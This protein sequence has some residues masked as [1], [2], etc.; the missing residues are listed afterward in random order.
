MVNSRTFKIAYTEEIVRDAVRAFVWKRGISSQKGLWA[1]EA[2]MACLLLWSLSSGH[3]GWLTVV[4]AVGVL[5][6]LCLI[7][8]MW[9]A[10]HRNTVGKY[11]RMP[12]HEAEVTFRDEG[13]EL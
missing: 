2:A 7:V 12:S 10:H 6:P 5:V 9:I 8:M 1:V 11:R 3:H 13:F 4:V